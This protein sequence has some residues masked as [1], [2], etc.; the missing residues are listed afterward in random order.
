MNRL[1]ITAIV[2]FVSFVIGS[3][4]LVALFDIKTINGNQVGVMETWFDGVIEEPYT[5]RTYW[6]LPWQRLEAYNV[7]TQVFVMNDKDEDSSGGGEGYN[8]GRRV[9]SYLVQ[10]QDSQDMVLSMKLQWTID[11]A[12]VV[13]LHKTIGPDGIEE[14]VIRPALQRIV[15]DEATTKSAIEVYSGA[16]LVALQKGIQDKLNDKKG[17]LHLRGINV[18]NF[19]IEHIKLDPE[20]VKEITG[21]Q[22]AIQK[23]MRS[24]QEEK[25][26]VAD[27]AKA[28]AVAQADYE[29]KL[30]Q[31]K[32]DKD[33]AVLASEAKQEQAI[34]Q[35]EGEKQKTV[36][37]AEGE[38][39][40]S[41]LQAQAIKAIGAA[42]A[43]AEKLKFAAFSAPGSEVYAKIEIAKAL[44]ES[45]SG[46]KG[47][48][49]SDMNV[50]TLG[51]NFNG[52]VERVVAGQAAASA[53]NPA[54]KPS[55]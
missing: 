32:R 35:A 52:A 25:A 7:A 3:L 47:Y 2:G 33:V 29:T 38:K 18:E 45:L 36:L 22:I 31:A 44:G 19:L 13:A 15:K 50:I 9:D 42:K 1:G 23:E 26:A 37:A 41:E 27:A 28:K 40:S 14:R 34:L 20:Y 16:G 17:E 6:V 49:P 10:S 30:V 21:R 51:E 48:L 54:V 55:N 53:V 39:E 46:I 24:R 11:P 5:P 12:R 43:E 4:L 8:V